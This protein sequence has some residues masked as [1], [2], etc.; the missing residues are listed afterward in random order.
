ML[1]ISS[2]KVGFFIIFEADG[3]I[4]I[5]KFERNLKIEIYRWNFLTQQNGMA[6]KEKNTT[7]AML[8]LLIKLQPQSYD[9]SQTICFEI[10]II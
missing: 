7:K 2:N 6:T 1:L 4:S 10:R 5:K 8:L 3:F 9:L